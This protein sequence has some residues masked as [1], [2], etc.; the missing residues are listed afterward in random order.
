[1]IMIFSVEL[2]EKSL[3]VSAIRKLARLDIGNCWKSNIICEV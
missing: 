1:M 3:Y 2:S